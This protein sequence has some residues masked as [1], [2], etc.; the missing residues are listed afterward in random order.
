MRGFCP[1]CGGQTRVSAIR[2]A[3]S[4]HDDSEYQ[5][6]K[7]GQRYQAHQLMTVVV[8][9]AQFTVKRDYSKITFKRED[10]ERATKR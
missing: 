5:C 4:V 1:D 6:L 3:L 10:I 9:K 7:C 8:P 2:T